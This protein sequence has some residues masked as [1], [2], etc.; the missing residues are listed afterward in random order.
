MVQGKKR[1]DDV[2][3]DMQSERV[4]KVKKDTHEGRERKKDKEL[5]SSKGQ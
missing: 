1:W 2:R 4:H 5:L 3:G